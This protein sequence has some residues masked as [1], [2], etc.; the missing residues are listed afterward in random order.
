[1]PNIGYNFNPNK[2]AKAIVLVDGIEVFRGVLRVIKA[3]IDKGV[4]TYETSVLGRLSDILFALGDKKLSDLDFSNLNHTL[5]VDEIQASWYRQPGAGYVYPL[6]DYG[7]S[8]DGINYPITGFRPAVYAL[9]YINRMFAQAGFTYNCVFF[10][11][12]YFKSLIIPTTE[13]V[14]YTQNAVKSRFLECYSKETYVVNRRVGQWREVWN[15]WGPPKNKDDYGFITISVD[16]NIGSRITIN[17]PITTSFQF[18]C[19]YLLKKAGAYLNIRKNGDTVIANKEL[20]AVPYDG[21]PAED[22]FIEIPKQK[23]NPGDIITMSMDISPGN[24]CTFH[25]GSFVVAPSPTDEDPYPIVKGA[26]VEMWKTIS[27]SVTQKDFFKSIIT[28]HNLYV[29]TDQTNNKNLFILPQSWFYDNYAGNAVDWTNKVDYSQEIEI[30]PMGQLGSKDFVLSYKKDSDYYNDD[31]Y[32]KKYNEVYGQ[33]RFIADN[34][35]EKD[36]TKVEVVFSPTPSV[37]IPDISQRVIP[38]IYKV[39]KDGIKQVDAFNIRILQ[40]AGLKPSMLTASGNSGYATWNISDTDGVLIRS[41]VF[42]PYAGMQDDPQNVTRDLCFGPPVEMFYAAQ[43]PFPDVG[44]FRYYWE[45]YLKE[46]TDKDSKLWKGYLLLT[47]AD[48][49]Q[50]DFKKL[51]K[52]DNTYFR[53]NKVSSYNPLGN[54]L[55]QVE[56]FKSS[57]RVEIERPG[58]I[59]WSD[60]GYLLHSDQSPA[61]IP[62]A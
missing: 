40:W 14:E 54:E 24:V 3:R 48:I 60:D 37:Q 59:K 21:R 36:E 41:F 43:N 32:F 23:W 2:A 30:T 10:A 25:P 58:F 20:N 13:K 47:P 18:R 9:E 4:V 33:K 55:T 34:D 35:F 45:D 27:T 6:I 31:R 61:R 44:M 16:E 12:P 52:I 57:V 19:T 29:F 51:V 39:N 15:Q 62:Y 49:S 8:V 46:I 42:Y 56:L 26:E 28:M 7:L 17:R 1:M 50:L 38:H 5:T 22:V 11:Q 53:L